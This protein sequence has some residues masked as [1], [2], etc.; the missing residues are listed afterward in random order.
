MHARPLIEVT[1]TATATTTAPAPLGFLNFFFLSFFFF[2]YFLG[3][4]SHA[5][6]EVMD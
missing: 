2:D 4:A 3:R 5:A 6:K 1:A